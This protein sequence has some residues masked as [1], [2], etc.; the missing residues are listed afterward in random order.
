MYAIHAIHID[1][2]GACNNSAVD[3]CDDIGLLLRSMPQALICSLPAEKRYTLLNNHFKPDSKFK[4]PN[5]YLD[6]CNRACQHKYLIDNP[7]FVYSMAE[8]AI[9]CLPCVLFADSTNLGQLVSEKFNHW[10]RKSM[11]F[12]SHNSTK[13]QLLALSRVDALKSA[14][15]KPGSDLFD[16][17]VQKLLRIG[18]LLNH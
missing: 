14:I 11:K 1:D 8:D 4:F 15:E 6:G 12:S 7:S 2:V 9:F 13:Y 17:L 16:R 10:T 18:L 3:V 5:R